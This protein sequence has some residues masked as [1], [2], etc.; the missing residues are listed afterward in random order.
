MKDNYILLA[1]CILLAGMGVY[2]GVSDF[3]RQQKPRHF[4]N[5]MLASL[6]MLALPVYC[7][8]IPRIKDK[9]IL[10]TI[11]L[12]NIGIPL[13]IWGIRNSLFTKK[14]N[15][16]VNAL[17]VYCTPRKGRTVPVFTYTYEGE[18]Y[19][20][21]A[22]HSVS[23]GILVADKTYRIYINPEKPTQ[24]IIFPKLMKSNKDI[25]IGGIVITL[26]GI[27]FFIATQF[28]LISLF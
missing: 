26:A 14:C 19:K 10:V 11:V 13:L 22:L 21:A 18:S 16:Q 17:C 4:S 20:A 25:L 2:A 9:N 8:I 15:Y 23:G 7:F 24:Y 28:N 3:I 6:V 5:A 1:S 27:G 12:L